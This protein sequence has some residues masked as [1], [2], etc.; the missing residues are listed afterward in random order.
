MSPSTPDP[1]RV[2]IAGGGVGALETALALRALAWR[3]I[4]I[5]LVAPDRHFVYRPV[6]VT[7]PFGLGRTIRWELAA[8]ARDRG[9]GL[10]R[11]A[12]ERVDAGAHRVI[13]Q[14]GPR[15]STTCSSSRWA[16]DRA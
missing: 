16:R 8:I 10:V 3:G 9:F 7:E 6:S 12:V 14:G 2:V 13:T 5:Q 15:S 1:L 11:D 4:T